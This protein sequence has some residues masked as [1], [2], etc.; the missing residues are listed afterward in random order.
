MVLKLQEK[1]CCKMSGCR[2]QDIVFFNVV[3]RRLNFVE[4]SRKKG[5]ALTF[6][7]V[8]YTASIF[9]VET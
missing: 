4:I 2:V 1:H 3:P 9:N 7:P 6:M 5:V 8:V